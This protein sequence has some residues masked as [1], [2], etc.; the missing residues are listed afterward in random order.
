MSSQKLTNREHEEI[1]NNMY[2]SQTTE[3][4]NNMKTTRVHS[5]G[6]NTI[7]KVCNDFNEPVFKTKE[8]DVNNDKC[9][10][11]VKTYNHHYFNCLSATEPCQP[12]THNFCKYHY[13]NATYCPIHPTFNR[14][15]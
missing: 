13:E 8:C 5:S 10:E 3:S 2:Q 11:P 14:I 15:L 6:K 12:S 9:E 7:E 1:N 4:P